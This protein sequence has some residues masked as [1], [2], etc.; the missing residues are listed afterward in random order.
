MCFHGFTPAPTYKNSMNT[1]FVRRK[2]FAFVRSRRFACVL[3]ASSFAFFASCGGGDLGAS[4]LRKAHSG[5]PR[6]SVLALLGTGSVTATGGDS[7]RVVNGFRHQRFLV[8]A[9]LMEVIWY[10][11]APGSVS[12]KITRE[13]ETPVVLASDTVAGWGWKYYLADGIKI[14]LPDP[15][16]ALAPVPTAPTAPAATPDSTARRLNVTPQ[17][18]TKRP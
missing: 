14:G 4:R 5:M 8:N 7:S 2:G 17:G 6:D 12:D 16:K 13:M 3:F 10:R 9:Q 11:E 1:L 15:L 18:S